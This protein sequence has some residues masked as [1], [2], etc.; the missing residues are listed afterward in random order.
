MLGCMHSFLAVHD[1]VVGDVWKDTQ[2]FISQGFS[3]ELE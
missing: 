3:E 2:Y 1:M